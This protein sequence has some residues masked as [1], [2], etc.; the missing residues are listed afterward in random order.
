MKVSHFRGLQA[1]RYPGYSGTWHMWMN[2]LGDDAV[3]TYALDSVAD[4][5]CRLHTTFANQS[6]NT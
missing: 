1:V 4:L 2:I 5:H 3:D 6:A